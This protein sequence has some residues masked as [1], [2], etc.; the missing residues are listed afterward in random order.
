MI[1]GYVDQVKA[2]IQ[3]LISQARA[4][5]EGRLQE[6]D[7]VVMSVLITGVSGKIGRLVATGLVD[8][9]MKVI[10]LI[11]AHGLT[12]RRRGA[13]PGGYTQTWR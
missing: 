9:E 4:L 3:R 7:G 6:S 8:R 12:L 2:R 13:A 1:R 5:R 11:A 10:G